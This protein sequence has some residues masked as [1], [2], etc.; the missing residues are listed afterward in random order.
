MWVR[1]LPRDGSHKE[2]S[3]NIGINCFCFGLLSCSCFSTIWC[4]SS[5]SRTNRSEYFLSL[6]FTICF[7]FFLY[8]YS[9]FIWNQNKYEQLFIELSSIIEKSKNFHIFQKK[10]ILYLLQLN[11]NSWPGKERDL[12][13]KFPKNWCGDQIFV[14]IIIENMYSVTT[15]HIFWFFVLLFRIFLV[16]I[17]W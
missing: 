3:L 4:F 13:K 5:T 17:F 15:G 16:Y 12:W 7:I 11:R 1:I 10:S 6:F 2:K 9:V 8:W 14:F